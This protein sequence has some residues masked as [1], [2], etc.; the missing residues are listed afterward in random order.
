MTDSGDEI[1]EGPMDMFSS[2]MSEEEKMSVM[3]YILDNYQDDD[4]PFTWF[5][6]GILETDGLTGSALA[7]VESHNSYT[8]D[9]MDDW[10]SEPECQ[11]KIQKGNGGGYDLWSEVYPRVTPAGDWVSASIFDDDDL[12]VILLIMLK[13]GVYDSDMCYVL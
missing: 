13:A 3:H 6:S 10:G 4:E 5:T 8:T 2:D 7:V 9:H 12:E 11:V 1:E